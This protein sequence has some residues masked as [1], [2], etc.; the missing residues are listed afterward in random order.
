[1]AAIMTRPLTAS[2]CHTW[3]QAPSDEL[4]DTTS[5]KYVPP[6]DARPKRFSKRIKHTWS[7]YAVE[8]TLSPLPH[9]LRFAV[10]ITEPVI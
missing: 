1:M 4:T 7:Q 2:T 9:Q 5:C 6:K 10:V 8:G 3:Q